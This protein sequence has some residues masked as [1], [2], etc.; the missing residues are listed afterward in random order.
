MAGFRLPVQE[1]ARPYF[2]L[3]GEV[4]DDFGARRAAFRDEH[5]RLA[6]EAHARGE[7]VLA[8]ALAEPPDKALLVF[9]GVSSESAH[10]FAEN[11]PYVRNGLVTRWEVRPW[12]VVI[13]GA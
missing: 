1:E 12:S 10:R 11:D 7:I 9:R 13:G 3:I 4:V 2:A 5:L 6:E 8:G